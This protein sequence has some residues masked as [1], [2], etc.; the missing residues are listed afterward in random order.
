MPFPGPVEES[1]VQPCHVRKTEHWFLRD[2]SK[3]LSDVCAR[4]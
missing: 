3:Y 1:D 2:L 4:G